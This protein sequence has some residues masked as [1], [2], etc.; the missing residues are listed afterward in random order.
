[1]CLVPPLGAG[2]GGASMATLQC[3]RAQAV[4]GSPMAAPLLA[5]GGWGRASA[6]HCASH[7]NTFMRNGRPRQRT[8]DGM[9][10]AQ[11]ETSKRFGKNRARGKF[12]ILGVKLIPPWDS[13]IFDLFRASDRPH[14]EAP[15]IFLFIKKYFFIFLFIKKYLFIFLL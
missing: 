12:C 8:E 4:C 2:K 1:M 10:W 7:T 13:F 5:D 14:T 11:V 15:N 6:Q 9:S 3:Q